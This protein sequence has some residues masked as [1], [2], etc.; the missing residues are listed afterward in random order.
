MNEEDRRL[1]VGYDF[2]DYPRD[3]SMV[4]SKAGSVRN[5]MAVLPYTGTGKIQS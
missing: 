3:G 1:M 5:S 4:G 2:A